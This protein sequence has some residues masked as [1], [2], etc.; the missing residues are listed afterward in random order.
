MGQIKLVQSLKMCREQQEVKLLEVWSN[1]KK[2]INLNYVTLNAF[3]I[4]IKSLIYHKAPLQTPKSL[5]SS[6]SLRLVFAERLS[7]SNHGSTRSV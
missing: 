1:K 2:Y 3:D 5:F 7:L 6:P 4:E